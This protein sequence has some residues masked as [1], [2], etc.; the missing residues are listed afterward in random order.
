[1]SLATTT[2]REKAPG[3]HAAKRPATGRSAASGGRR[4]ISPG[5][6]KLVDLMDNRFEIAGVRFGLDALI[7]VVPG[8]GDFFGMVM[9]TAVIL[10]ALRH[11][12]SL[13]V[14]GRMLLNLWIDAAIG[15]VPLVG[16]AFDVFFKA[17]R[18]NLRLLEEN[19]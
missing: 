17:H 9:G 13:W 18:R 5:L 6:R 8:F 15:S 3:L 16:D 12:V 11:R 10:E 14:I 7:G 2:L 19:I 1:M 4:K